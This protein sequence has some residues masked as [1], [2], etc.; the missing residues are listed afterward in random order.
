MKTR[1]PMFNFTETLDSATHDAIAEAAKAL[2]D[3]G[4]NHKPFKGLSGIDANWNNKLKR[5][6]LLK[7]R[8]RKAAKLAKKAR[9]NTN[10]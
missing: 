4:Y 8:N 1:N 7:D 5:Q 2:I 6:R 9:R 10:G 3:D